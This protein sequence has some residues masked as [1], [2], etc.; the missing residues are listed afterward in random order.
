MVIWQA[1][2]PVQRF[3]R[4]YLFHIPAN[5]NY[6]ILVITGALKTIIIGG[7]FMEKILYFKMQAKNLIRDFKTQKI[8]SEGICVYS[9]EFFHDIDDLILSFDIDEEHFTLMNAQ[10]LI[11]YLAG[12]EKWSDL[13]HAS[14]AALELGELLLNNRERYDQP[15]RESWDM[16][17]DQLDLSD[18]ADESKLEIFKLV[19]LPQMN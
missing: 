12:F 7:I 6:F 18:I 13:L 9:P 3:Y 17:L 10:H 2:S 16:Y 1:R 11:A 8:D 19:F 4:P 14:D 15:L 5:N